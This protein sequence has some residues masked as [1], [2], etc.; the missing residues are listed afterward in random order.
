MI[1]GPLGG[2][3]VIKVGKVSP[4]TIAPTKRVSFRAKRVLE[5]VKGLREKQGGEVEVKGESFPRER[6]HK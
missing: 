3:R 4:L 2:D 5:K 1:R 6:H